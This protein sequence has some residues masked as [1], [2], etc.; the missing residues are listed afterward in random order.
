MIS[1]T[2]RPVNCR[3]ADGTNCTI[4]SKAVEHFKDGEG[5]VLLWPEA[6]NTM[7]D[8]RFQPFVKVGPIV[9]E[10]LHAFA[11]WY[12]SSKRRS[13][14][15]M[16]MTDTVSVDTESSLTVLLVALLVAMVYS[17]TMRSERKWCQGSCNIMY[18]IVELTFGQSSNLM[19][20]LTGSIG[21]KFLFGNFLLLLFFGTAIYRTIFG[22]DLTVSQRTAN[23]DT[24]EQFNQSS[25]YPIILRDESIHN[26]ILQSDKDGSQS[27]EL[28]RL[29][30]SRLTKKSFVSGPYDMYDDFVRAKS[31]MINTVYFHSIFERL[32]CL[33][34]ITKPELVTDFYENYDGNTLLN[35][36]HISDEKFLPIV[37]GYSYN[38]NI[39]PKLE[40]RLDRFFKGQLEFGLSQFQ[41]K[42]KPKLSYSL[43]QIELCLNSLPSEASRYGNVPEPVA[44]S[45]LENILRMSGYLVS[46]AGL[47][48]I[49]EI[50]YCEYDISTRKPLIKKR[51][52][53]HITIHYL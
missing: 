1:S 6:L 39:S 45:S 48:V 23:L 36:Y 41:R 9:M 27:G 33:G 43:D 14:K 15:V 32:S 53:V 12:R 26:L 25:Y 51:R 29:I 31:A 50:L 13:N 21:L 16:S 18:R 38:R 17:I 22:T 20:K 10:V 40:G 35:L 52:R 7:A 34:V 8:D 4:F 42:M 24:I 30:R 37:L 5:D 28:M 47:I 19:N 44:L 11:S 3:R 49:L 46:I 2:V